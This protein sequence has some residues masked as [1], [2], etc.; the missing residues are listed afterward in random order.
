M[1]ATVKVNRDLNLVEVALTGRMT[2][3][4]MKATRKR[5]QAFSQD[6]QLERILVNA[7]ALQDLPGT[8]PLYEFASS[9]LEVGFS[10]G[11]RLG[12]VVSGSTGDDFKFI[13][14][15]AQNRAFMFRQFSTRDEAIQW[16]KG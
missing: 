10:K 13:E 2:L 12:V 15:V 4:D 1:A 5:V 9:F 7:S 3:A 11:I 14:N 6:Y 16:L 8:M